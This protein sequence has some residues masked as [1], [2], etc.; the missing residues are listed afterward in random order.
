MEK[1]RRVQLL[2]LANYDELTGLAN[3]RRF[4]EKLDEMLRKAKDSNQELS[5]IIADID[6]FKFYNDAH[7]HQMGDEVLRVLG[8]LFKELV[9]EPNVPARYGGEEFAFI[10]SS[11]TTPEVIKLAEK[12]RTIVEQTPFYGIKEQPGGKLTLSIGIAS[13]PKNAETKEE[14]IRTA[15]QAL[16]KAK[17][18]SRNK[19][20]IYFSVLD[21]LKDK[22]DHSEQELFNSV[23]TLISIINAKD[24]YTFGHSERVIDYG[25]RLAR[26]LMLPEEEI[27]VLKYGSFLHD[28]GKIEIERDILNKSESLTKNEWE[29]LKQHPVWGAEIIKPLPSLQRVVPIVLYHHENF[30]GTGYPIGLKGEEIPLTARIIRIIDSFD[31]MTTDRP[32]KKGMSKVAALNELSSFSGTYYDPELVLKFRRMIEEDLLKDFEGWREG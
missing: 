29:I 30:D 26:R 28:I 24:R 18:M 3:H 11:L 1:D 8:N 21:E 12:M 25:V 19:V 2:H 6:H 17:F 9:N 27:A 31:A 20:E 15:D 16:Y 23:R 32:Y 5:L 14:L 22:I 4:H 10:I 7:G 13:F